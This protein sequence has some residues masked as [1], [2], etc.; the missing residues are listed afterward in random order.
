MYLNL[1][2]QLEKHFYNENIWYKLQPLSVTTAKLGSIKLDQ[3][4]FFQQHFH[5]FLR[6][7][8]IVIIVVLIDS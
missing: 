8:L 6:K 3:W 7:F 5:L 1:S 4:G 2:V